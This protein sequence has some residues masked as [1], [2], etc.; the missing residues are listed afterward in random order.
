M[1]ATFTSVLDQIAQIAEIKSNLFGAID[2]K[3]P[4]LETWTT[5]SPFSL[6]PDAVNSIDAESADIPRGSK[7]AYSTWAAIPEEIVTYI[8]LST[9]TDCSNMFSDCSNLVNVGTSTDMFNMPS[10]TDMSRCFA[11]CYA[12][13]EVYIKGATNWQNCQRT[14]Q[15][16][17]SLTTVSFDTVPA[18]VTSCEGMFEGCTALTSLVSMS[19]TSSVGVNC[20]AMYKSSGL[21]GDVS[22]SF[23]NSTNAYIKYAEELFADCAISSIPDMELSSCVSCRAMCQIINSG[24]AQL[25]TVGKLNTT[26]CEN[27]NYMFSGQTKLQSIDSIN[28]QACTSAVGIFTGCNSITSL[29]ILNL[30]GSESMSSLDLSD[31]TQWTTGLSDT[32]QNAA[33]RTSNPFT[34]KLSATTK[35]ALTTE[36]TTTLTSLGYTIE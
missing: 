36:Q 27:M 26:V 33:D 25:L 9:T 30:G 3:G 5:T 35:A 22:S 17:K 34:L 7:F 19:F 11:N 13:K 14:F 21:I 1:A 4:T 8:Q 23:A 28:M 10:K 29:V 32:I 16:C 12:L 2:S 18:A 15:G 24:K 6:Y 20:S 31:L